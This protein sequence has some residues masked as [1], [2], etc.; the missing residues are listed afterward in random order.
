M[1]TLSA[2]S[3]MSPCAGA[4]AS[5]GSPTA[6]GTRAR[7][8]ERRRAQSLYCAKRRPKTARP[9]R[10]KAIAPYARYLSCLLVLPQM[11][12]HAPFPKGCFDLIGHEIPRTFL[13]VGLRQQVV[14]IGKLMPHI[15]NEREPC[16]LLG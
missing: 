2:L 13:V 12:P 14:V 9:W 4:A 15:G 3:K 11:P 5:A 7:K 10:N 1:Q 16:G 6:Y 8:A